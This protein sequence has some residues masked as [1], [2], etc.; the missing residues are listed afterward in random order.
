M[1]PGGEWNP[2]KELLTVQKRMNNLF[3]RALART[4]FE[5]HEEVDTW[6]PVCDVFATPDA[7]VLCLELPGL[8]QAEIDQLNRFAPPAGVG[9]DAVLGGKGSEPVEEGAGLVAV[10]EALFGGGDDPPED[11]LQVG[12]LVLGQQDLD[13]DGVERRLGQV[14]V[15]DPGAEDL[16]RLGALDPAQVLELHRVAQA[17]DQGADLGDLRGVGGLA[18]RSGGGRGFFRCRIFCGCMDG[19]KAVPEQERG[20]NAGKGYRST[21]NPEFLP[22]VPHG[23]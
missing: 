9:V 7:L 10:G 14:L 12:E 5:T 2:L 6:T 20:N 17:V 15:A 4:D 18:R 22:Q 21:G 8:E 19:K 11:F 13:G 1:R 23:G 3:E 16:R